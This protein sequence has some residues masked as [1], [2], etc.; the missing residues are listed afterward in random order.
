MLRLQACKHGLRMLVGSG[1]MGVSK[2]TH[3]LDQQR[4]EGTDRVAASYRQVCR[5]I[6]RWN[7]LRQ[8]EQ[9]GVLHFFLAPGLCRNSQPCLPWVAIQD[10][11]SLTYTAGCPGLG[12]ARRWYRPCARNSPGLPGWAENLSKNSATE[13]SVSSRYLELLV[14]L[15]RVD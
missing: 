1:F 12:F 14:C 11:N 8:P 13:W 9:Y 15:T 5:R 4:C 6:M 3:E 7:S 10:P 2:C